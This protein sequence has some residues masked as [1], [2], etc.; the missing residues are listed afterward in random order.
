MGYLSSLSSLLETRHKKE[1]LRL[2]PRT[3]T[4]IVQVLLRTVFSTFSKLAS[5]GTEQTLAEMYSIEKSY[6]DC[7]TQLDAAVLEENQLLV[8]NSDDDHMDLSR[9]FCIVDLVS[10]QYF[11]E[12][13]RSSKELLK[14]I[15]WFANQRS[16]PSNSALDEASLRN[17]LSELQ[18]RRQYQ[19]V[20]KVKK[21]VCR[22]CSRHYLFVD[23]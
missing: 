16:S 2:S 19:K 22:F 9:A 7:L 15:A 17:L 8:L 14:V 4:L 23:R 11:E 12:Q 1:A 6:L 10:R 3:Y 5:G 20:L 13:G 21:T 18:L